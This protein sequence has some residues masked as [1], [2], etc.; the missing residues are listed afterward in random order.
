MV[1]PALW[2]T[3]FNTAAPQQTRKNVLGRWKIMSDF[4]A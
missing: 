1:A 2:A 4:T 3:I